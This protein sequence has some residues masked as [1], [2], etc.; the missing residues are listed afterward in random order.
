[1]KFYHFQTKKHIFF[2]TQKSRHIE[3][4]KLAVLL[5]CYLIG[6]I[7]FCS[8]MKGIFAFTP[9]EEP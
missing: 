4:R 9:E 8:M 7:H 2:W 6:S 3:F 1:M 5:T